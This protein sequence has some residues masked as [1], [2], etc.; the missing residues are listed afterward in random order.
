MPETGK[1]ETS[2]KQ[3]YCLLI[4]L[5]ISEDEG[6]MVIRKAKELPDCM[7]PVISQEVVL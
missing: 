4:L 1:H 2:S 3:N 7:V 5:L 6:K